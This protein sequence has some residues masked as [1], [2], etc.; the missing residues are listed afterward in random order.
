MRYIVNEASFGSC[1]RVS[2]QDEIVHSI[3]ST[4]LFMAIY[5]LLDLVYDG[6]LIPR[7]ATRYLGD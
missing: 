6:H 2:V 5:L 4:I 7:L 1:T 3:H